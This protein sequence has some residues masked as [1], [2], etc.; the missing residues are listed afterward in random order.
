MTVEPVVS[1]LTP[2]RKP[3]ARAKAN[4]VVRLFHEGRRVSEIYRELSIG[5]ASVYRALKLLESGSAGA[6]AS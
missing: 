4:D 5:S 3:T 2:G 1:A 6:N